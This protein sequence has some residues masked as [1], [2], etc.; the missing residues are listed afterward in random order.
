MMRQYREAKDAHPGMVLLFRMGDFYELFYDDAA[1]RR[2]AA[3]PH[4]HQP[5]QGSTNPVPMAGVPVPRARRLPAEADPGR[6]S[7]RRSASR[8]RTRDWPRASSTRESPASSRRARSPTTRCSIRARATTWRPSPPAEERRRRLAWLELSTGGFLA[9]DVGRAAGLADELGPAAAR[10][11]CLLPEA[12][13]AR[14]D[15][16]RLA[17]AVGLPCSPT[18]PTWPFAPRRSAAATCSTHFGIATLDGFGFDDD[19][20]VAARAAGALLD[21]CPARRRSA[22]CA[23]SRGSAPYRRGT[24][25]LHRRGDAPQPG[26]DGD[27]ARRRARRLAA[28]GPR[29]DARPR[30][31]RGCSREWLVHPLTDPAAI[32]A[33]LDAV[34]GARR[35]TPCP[36]RESCAS[37]STDLRRSAAADGP[38]A[39]PARQPPRPG[40]ARRTRSRVLAQA[41][42]QAHGPQEP[43]LLA[44]ARRPPRPAA[45]AARGC[46]TRRLVDEPPLAAARR[47]R[48]PR[49]AIDAELDELREHRRAAARSGSPASRPTRSHAP[50]SRPRRS[51]STR[52]S[53]TTSRSRTP[54]DAQ[55]ARRLHPQADAQERR[56]LHHAG[57]EGVRGEGAS[58]PRTAPSS[59]STSSSSR[60]ATRGRR[61]TSRPLQT[62]PRS[63]PR[64]DVLSA[65]AALRAAAALRPAGPDRRRADARDRATAGIPCST[66]CPAGAF[67][68]NDVRLEPTTAALC[69]SPARTWPARAPTS[70]RSR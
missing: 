46:S 6:P 50:A 37:C 36:C 14:V 12:P 28:V 45:R 44:R 7:G 60:S 66:R 17:E 24:H 10:R 42:G 3:R 34:G 13:P 8:S 40:R 49:R 19:S 31:A 22:A 25:L 53:A 11:R 43:R 69:S 51:A 5:R 58:A 26:T 21:L 54:T 16:S 33:R 52:S 55:G 56:A 61:S 63:W 2:A 41:Q 48:H 18:R 68:P 65:L 67:V 39:R 59:S 23:T 70:A 32:A 4:A 38:R 15:G 64:V 35:T 9:T 57:A 29:R 47:R 62:L 30:W 20:P 27:A 1:D